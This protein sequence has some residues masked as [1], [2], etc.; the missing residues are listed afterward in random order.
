MLFMYLLYNSETRQSSS[1]ERIDELHQPTECLRQPLRGR[2]TTT[3]V[4]SWMCVAE[5]M[6]RDS[7]HECADRMC[8][9]ENDKTLCGNSVFYSQM[10]YTDIFRELIP[11]SLHYA[12]RKE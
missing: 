9:K 6:L 5:E 4:D 10:L 11:A 8:F 2:R 12:G 1:T 3:V 7:F